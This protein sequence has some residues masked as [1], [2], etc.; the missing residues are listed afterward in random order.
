[1]HSRLVVIALFAAMVPSGITPGFGQSKIASKSPAKVVSAPD[2]GKLPL[3]FEV[4]QGQ[5]DSR[6]HFLSRGRGYSL[7]LTDSTAVLALTKDAVPEHQTDATD[8]RHAG[9]EAPSNAHRTDVVRMELTGASRHP[10]VE[11]GDRLPGVASYF[12]G[13][14]PANWRGGIPTFAKVQYTGVY[15]GVN[16]VYYGNQRRLEYDF[17]VAS[18]AN[19]KQIRL[20]FAGARKLKL[21]ADGNLQV[22]AADGSIAFQRPLVYQVDGSRREPVEGRF[23]LLANNS[24]GFDLGKY[25]HARPLVIDPVL[26]YSTYLGGTNGGDFGGDYADSIAVDGA[27]NAYVTG[28]VD[29]TNFPVTQGSYQIVNTGENIAFVAK[30]NAAGTQ[31]LYSTYIGGPNG[32]DYG[33]GIAVDA[34]GDAYVT[35]AT[36]G[37]FPMT[38]GAFQTVEAGY[39]DTFVAKLNRTGTG[40]LYS[41]YLGGSLVDVAAGIAID[42]S[43]DAFVTGYSQSLNYPVT[44]G[45]FQ[46]TNNGPSNDHTNA[47]V[48]EVNPA[49]S[50][51]VYSTYLG[52]SGT[53]DFATAI[54]VNGSGDAYVTGYTY[55][56]DFPVSQ[57]AFQ[58]VNHAPGSRNAFVT[59]LNQAGSSL[60]Y[61]TY[62]GGTYTDSAY[63]IA[64][65]SEGNAYVAGSAGST[66]FPVTSGA[67]QTTK[68]ETFSAFITKLNPAGT[69]LV[70]STY[71]GGGGALDASEPAN[72]IAVDGL[73]DAF[74]IGTTGST[75]FP[76]T[77]GA[78]QTTSPGNN[79]AFLS[80]L[81]PA[82]TALLY[83]TYFG[84]SRADTGY[85]ITLDAAGD[86]YLA[87]K[88]YSN[89]FPVTAGVFQTV[90]NGYANGDNNAFISKLAIGGET[91]ITLSSSA[92]PQQEGDTVTFTAVVTPAVSEGVPT[93]SVVFSINGSPAATE[94][95][96][97]TGTATY[98]T[99]VLEAGTHTI[100]AAYSGDANYLASS[101]NLSETIDSS[102]PA[103]TTPTPGSAL[104]GSSATFTWSPGTGITYYQLRLGTTGVGSSDLYNSGV[105]RST[106][107][108]VSD[109]PTDGLPVY[110]RLYYELNNVWQT[111]DY[112]YSTAGTVIPA[113]MT[114]PTPGTTLPGANV[115]FIWSAGDGPE[116]Y[117]LRV[118]TGG[119]GSANLY[120]SGAIRATQ[121]A[122]SGLPTD[123]ITVY[124]RLYSETANTWQ[125]VD[126]TYQSYGMASPPAL[127]AP[128]PGST[129]SGSSATFT[130]SPGTGITYYQLRLGTTGVGSSDLYNSGTTRSTSASVSDLPTDGLPVYARLY[131]ELNNVW[132]TLDYAYSTAGTIIPAAMTSPAPG[133]TLPGASVTFIWSAGDGPEYY[134][135][136]IGTGGAGSANLYSSGAIRATQ[137]AVSGL[138]TD[139]ITVYVRLYSETANT[140]QYV[141]YTYQSYG[142][143]SPPALTAPT[144]GGTLTGSSATFTWSPGTGIT[145]YQLRLGTTGAG[146]SDLYNSGT[147]R[148][149][150]AS[151]SDLPTDGL[152]VYAR[153]Y[154]E[155]NN[156]WQTLDYTYSTA[157]TIIPAAMTS[158]APG[159]TLPGASVTFI[160]TAGDGP[161]YYQLR[162]GTGGAGS[163]NL[164]NSGA[165]RA[166]QAAVSGLPTDGITVYVRLYSE[167]ANSWQYIDYTY[168]EASP[169]P[170]VESILYTF[171]GNGPGTA[172]GW[173]PSGGLVMDSLGNLYGTTVNGGGSEDSGTVFKISPSGQETILHSF[174]ASTDGVSPYG[175][176]VMDAQGNLYGTTRGGG[177]STI[178]CGE[179]I[180]CGGS[181]GSVFKITADGTETILHSFQWPS[182]DG[183][184]PDDG[185]VMDSGGNLYGTTSAGGNST[186]CGTVFK[187]TPGGAETVLY[188]FSGPDGCNP[189]EED[190][191]G[192]SNGGPGLVMDADGNLYGT[193]YDGGASGQG[194]VF[195]MAPNGTETV[196]HSFA[197]DG[198]DGYNPLGGL[199]NDNR[200]NLYGSTSSGGTSVFGTI[201]KITPSGAESI[202][203]NFNGNGLLWP[204]PGLLLD[205]HQ[206]LY[207]TSAGDEPI[208]GAV[209]QLAPSGVL[210]ILHQFPG[211]PGDSDGSYPQGRLLLAA[212]G[213]LYGATSGGDPSNSGTVF[214]LS[215]SVN[216]T[217][218]PAFSISPGTYTSSQTVTIFDANPNATIYYTV[219]GMIASSYSGTVYRGPVTISSTAILSAIAV[220]PDGT[221]SNPIM[222][223]YAIASTP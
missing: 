204:Q 46:T 210:T 77:T 42:G 144:P 6:V 8:S 80:K 209:F 122:V 22:M 98:P 191:T 208:P 170:Q 202:L 124:V 9:P 93:G 101:A 211:Y 163:A 116:Y 100:E 217:P 17:L 19:P 179:G 102:A 96:D 29:S 151:V 137:A 31:L 166:T 63:G 27:G 87:G 43:G 13:K 91:T 123:G 184:E 104:S 219:S 1:M 59:A 197:N 165:I 121:A 194:V 119:A 67:Y 111:L 153:L 196:I 212:N 198:T 215:P 155:L 39:T 86:A 40:L 147:T 83:S 221:A 2:Y 45:A 76:V 159:T 38:L 171:T 64:L 88:T 152:P 183:L 162:I 136:R 203:F 62:L 112:A 216:P 174:G 23:S 156:V 193:T 95:L 172:D 52:G 192:L 82:G 26:V 37:G 115:T 85:A 35:G 127:T 30:L 201:F 69:A 5:V 145:Y 14:D 107:A 53:G 143:A 128:T 20:R 154:Y 71:L 109:L 108:A 105:T 24:V 161:E 176:L 178:T 10:Q 74:V 97:G 11:G 106:S 25:D 75:N 55:S 195:K 65:D 92:N 140:W 138:P 134:Q 18:G 129:L 7:F 113:A 167:T 21:D 160:W 200:G 57:G 49:G 79:S 205:S 15:P 94:A 56:S 189:G 182:T 130:W 207:G 33:T 73:G 125:Y 60:V 149:T 206:N 48:T 223:N 164:Y 58:F 47:F 84:G 110:A 44:A 218:V 168:T 169:M 222:A 187:V 199:A 4:N 139:G 132:Q 50:G 150:S 103:L 61:S 114:S 146:S 117:Q 118:G 16:L 141:D 32:D 214:G 89:N 157:G 99:S 36:G 68:P 34:S 180:V 158:P 66:D 28:Q 188:S 148:S 220:A 78:Y 3:S 12:I 177:G 186:G 135:L 51:L 213:S 190:V 175:G 120:N 81:N 133:T 72:G 54:A 90:N 131:Y 173:S 181:S 70:Y 185:L 142:M 126:Y 41:T